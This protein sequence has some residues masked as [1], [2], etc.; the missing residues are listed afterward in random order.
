MVPKPKK[1]EKDELLH[2]L[3]P[4]HEKV[5]QQPDASPFRDPVDPVAL[6]CPDYFDIIKQP[7]DLSTIENKLKNGLYTEPREYCEDMRLMFRNAFTYN[8]EKSRVHRC[9]KAVS[10]SASKASIP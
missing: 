3:M 9:T 1:W 2:H 7:M 5:W 6:N 10:H 4:L 8:N